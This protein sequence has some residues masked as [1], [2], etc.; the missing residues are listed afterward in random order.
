[1]TILTVLPSG[2]SYDV[3]AGATLLQALLGVGLA[4]A[5]KCDGKAEC[6]SCHLFVQEGRKSLS[7][8][9][10]TENEK[11]D[12]IVGVGSKSRLACQAVLGDEPVTVELL[13]FV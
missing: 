7:K 5:H 12:A 2:K 8:I 11:L 9:Q 3:A 10:R 1:M 4:I 13:S 6:G